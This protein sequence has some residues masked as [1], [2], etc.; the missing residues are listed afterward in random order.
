MFFVLPMEQLFTS[1]LMTESEAWN[2]LENEIMKV[3][4]GKG[5]FREVFMRPGPYMNL[6]S[7]FPSL[8]FFLFYV[9]PSALHTSGLIP[10]WSLVDW[11]FSGFVLHSSEIY[12]GL[13]W[14]DRD[15]GQRLFLRRQGKLEL[16]H[17]PQ[18][19]G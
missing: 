16:Y 3:K 17:T 4:I 7:K 11:V 10:H 2:D 18:E 13:Y 9:F 12:S 5:S 14:A 8:L 19:Q 6:S 15:Q 1:S